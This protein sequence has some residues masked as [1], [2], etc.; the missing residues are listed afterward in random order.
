LP[1][2]I[3]MTG[4]SKHFGGV[5]A[6]A[7]V[8]LTIAAGEVHCLAGEN[9]SGKST[10]IKI[11]S[12]VQPPDAGGVIV[13]DG[14][15]YPHLT[16]SDSTRIGIQVIYQD[17]SLFPDLTVAENIAFAQHLN[18]VR[19]VNR[20][21]IRTTA[22][23]A[24]ERIG[25]SLN[26]EAKVGDLSIAQR[27]L[28]AICRALAGEARLVIMDEPTASLTRT[29][30]DTLLDITRELKRRGIAVVFV[31]H[32]LDEVLEIAERVTVLRDGRKLGTW[33]AQEM[34]PRRLGSLMTGHEFDYKIAVPDLS[35]AP[36]VL[37]VRNLS[38]AGD[39]EDVSLD[40][41]RGEIL[42]VIGLLGSGR[43][44]L[45]LSLFGMRPPERGEIRL[46][47]TPVTLHS[48][49]AAIDQGIAYVSEDRLS[50]G[51][52]LEQP[53]ASNIVLSILEKLAGP[54]GLLRMDRKRGAVGNWIEQLGIKVSDPENPV[55]T[56]SGGNQQRVVLAKWLATQPRVLILDSP[57]VGVDINA[58]DGIYAIV[59]RLAA[60][61]MAVMMISDEIPEVLYHSHRILVM[62]G[63]RLKGEFQPAQISETGLREAIDA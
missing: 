55:R 56:L 46:N 49:R 21:R 54:L 31:S 7:D 42:G 24:I 28:V 62:H 50:L 35:A 22:K 12:G 63:G 20:R 59:K 27:Q 6:L 47:G 30:V 4:I 39:F 52:V 34:T 38:R 44:E 41:R 29:E 48:N 26:P 11:I 5:T 36:V 17:L 18:G 45:A 40:L 10:L 2:F 43:T 37:S 19:G 16:P 9:G 61:G 58:K 32:R 15:E 33:D 13:I 51:L 8:D 57:T 53:I 60:S 23:A 14:V 25:V 3:E 1:N